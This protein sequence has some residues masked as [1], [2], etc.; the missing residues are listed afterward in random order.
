MNRL[1]LPVAGFVAV[2]FCVLV[3]LLA[4]TVYKN[5]PT[6]KDSL[7][8]VV[9]AAHDLRVGATLSEPDIR[10]ASIPANVA[11]RNA[12]HSA[13]GIIGRRVIL[14]IESGEFILPSKLAVENAGSGL[15]YLIPPGMRA[16]SVPLG[17]PPGFVDPPL[18]RPFPRPSAVH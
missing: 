3:V 12:Y 15:P 9:L 16:V 10:L 18:E 14:P 6:N 5:P 2:A 7:V 4:F 8:K 1:R 13:T 17:Q 11:P